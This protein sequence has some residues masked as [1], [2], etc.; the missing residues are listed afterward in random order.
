MA[1]SEAGEFDDSFSQQVNKQMLLC[2]EAML[3]FEVLGHELERH[4]FGLLS[5]QTAVM[6]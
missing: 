1:N 3:D 2:E 4:Y 6:L 5:D